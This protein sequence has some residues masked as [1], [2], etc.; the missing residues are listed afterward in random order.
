MSENP[1]ESPE[2]YYQ[3]EKQEQIVKR[4]RLQ[5]VFFIINVFLGL[6]IFL[7]VTLANL[8]AWNLVTAIP[9]ALSF[10]FLLLEV[11]AY[12]NQVRSLEGLLGL[13]VGFLSLFTVYAAIHFIPVSVILSV[14]SFILSVYCF[15][16]G[17]YRFKGFN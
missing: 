2:N 7:V 3:A 12:V 15:A 1:Y 6:L 11:I 4:S 8:F 5:F 17:Y 10:T 16:C 9:S 13:F 14:F